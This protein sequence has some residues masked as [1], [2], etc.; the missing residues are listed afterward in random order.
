MV[1]TRIARER[2]RLAAVAAG[3]LC[4]GIAIAAGP[5][6]AMSDG[7][8]QFMDQA[9]IG[10]TVDVTLGK[11]SQERAA[12]DR[13]KALGLRLSQD[14]A[15]ALDELRR[16]AKDKGIELPAVPDAKA[17]AAIAPLKRL[18]GTG[19][20]AAY[21][22]DRVAARQDD[23]AL[24]QKEVQSGRDADLKAHARKVLPTLREHLVL[25]RAAQAA[26]APK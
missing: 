10:A 16:I 23:V 22:A 8:R 2:W 25:A 26:L 19:F 20:D 21:V 5:V 3:V 17:L 11:L 18:A 15:Q 6:P 24:F 7:D 4:A 14:R 9:A 1:A 12:S 13:V